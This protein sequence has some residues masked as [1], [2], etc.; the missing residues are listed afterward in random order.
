M[1]Q[2]LSELIADVHVS[3]ATDNT[4]AARL[5]VLL[6]AQ[7]VLLSAQPFEVL[8]VIPPPV[9]SPELP[10][11]HTGLRAGELV[12]R[13]MLTLASAGNGDGQRWRKLCT[14]DDTPGAQACSIAL[15]TPAITR[16]DT[17]PDTQPATQSDAS[18]GTQPPSL[19]VAAFRRQPFSTAEADATGEFAYHLSR[20][21]PTTPSTSTP[22]ALP[23]ADYDALP[24]LRIEHGVA[25][26]LCP[27]MQRL[28]LSVESAKHIRKQLLTHAQRACY[29]G[30]SR[31]AL[32]TSCGRSLVFVI[33][34]VYDSESDA[35][36]T[37]R[38]STVVVFGYDAE[39]LL[40]VPNRYLRALYPITSQQTEV[41]LALVN[42]LSVE[43][44]AAQLGVAA[45]TVR[46]HISGLFRNMGVTS[47]VAL[48]R[49]LLQEILA[50]RSLT[51]LGK[52]IGVG[53]RMGPGKP[54]RTGALSTDSQRASAVDLY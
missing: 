53:N 12:R 24:S 30:C 25:I 19:I 5:A 43:E 40:S 38:A 26:S 9:A 4:L 11:T 20:R 54:R 39:E 3:H 45:N 35:A 44:T 37:R 22:A 10:D 41:A 33:L 14:R 31:L 7:I 17:R 52:F 8:A 46:T 27:R 21:Q 51:T 6:S 42:G 2:A 48:T 16:P 36:R 15:G 49:V 13:A 50:L 28:L 34:P 1:R 18:T 47:R 23:I 32:K 29:T